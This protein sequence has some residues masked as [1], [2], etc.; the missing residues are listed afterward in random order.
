MAEI[1]WSDPA[2]DELDRIAAYIARD[3]P[4][5]AARF[6]ARVLARVE[7]LAF[8]PLAGRTPRELAGTRYRQ[9]VVAPVRIFYRVDGDRVFIVHVMRGERR[10]RRADF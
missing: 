10:I 1:I 4:V 2:L 5:A 7:Q 9:L 3:K 8:F 6:M